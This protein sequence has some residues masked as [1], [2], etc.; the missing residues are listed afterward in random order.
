VDGDD[1]AR[2]LGV[3]RR[4]VGTAMDA[5]AIA[6]LSAGIEVA[7]LRAYRR[8]VGRRTREVVR[9]LHGED[10]DR[11]VDP[12]R[13]QRLLAAGVLTE[14]ARWLAD[15]WASWTAVRFLLIPMTRHQFTHLNDARRLRAKLVRGRGRD[16]GG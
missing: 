14:D 7:E 4:D 1:R 12:A 16:R 3:S 15:V 11:R 5:A 10:L 2:R 13:L 8:A 6:E 9:Q